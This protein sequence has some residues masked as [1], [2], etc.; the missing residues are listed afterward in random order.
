MEE[1]YQRE[2][3]SAARILESHGEYHLPDYAG[4]I[5]KMLCS[6]AR[7]VPTGKFFGGEEVQF[8]GSVHYDFWYLD[9]ENMLTHESFSTDYEFSCPRGN[10]TDGGITVT[11]AQF[12]LRPSGP[13]RVSAKASVEGKIT[14]LENAECGCV[15]EE[16][17]RL[18]K[19]LYEMEA[20]HRIFFAPKEREFAQCL[21][22]PAALAE[23]EAEIL[24]TEANVQIE[25]AEAQDGEALLRGYIV[26]SAVVAVR[27]LAP[28]R[29]CERYPFEEHVVCEEC[30]AD[31]DLEATAFV[32][33]LTA[34]MQD[35]QEHAITLNAICEFDCLAE[36]NK[37]V[38]I[39]QDAF[40]EHS[41]TSLGTETLEYEFFGG[42]KTFLRRVDLRIP[43][44]E[45]EGSADG[46]FHTVVALKNTMCA[47]QER[48]LVFSAEAEVTAL[49]YTFSEDGAPSFGARK[50]SAP[51][52]LHLPLAE[53]A[54]SD[55]EYTVDVEAFV[56]DC[57]LEDGNLCATL[58][59]QLIE[60]QQA[61]RTAPCVRRVQGAPYNKESFAPCATLYFPS[62]TD[63]LWSVAKRYAVSPVA[64]A[65]QN[66]I[67][68][69]GGEKLPSPI[70]IYCK[71]N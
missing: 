46:L 61:H 60:K 48:E 10:A 40:C 51:I 68:D 9:S 42:A 41:V 22:L 34:Q 30:S 23:Q 29:I 16:G 3:G 70:L 13:R 7:I 25:S 11:V 63:C 54:C 49:V 59:L 17:A 37:T 1:T 32:T 39:V 5:K 64:L 62:E 18:H 53:L 28:M 21:V 14:L 45:D 55:G 52:S 6:S 26:F 8:A 2:V 66:H 27:G 20:G 24:G 35:S 38:S 44:Q 15:V 12:S 19:Q 36:K 47:P 43:L 58:D 31:M 33:S 67:H 65:A 50:A 4:D 69:N 57:F 71:N 56:F